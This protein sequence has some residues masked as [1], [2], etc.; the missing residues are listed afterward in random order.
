[1]EKWI[2]VV[3]DP[4]GL[5]GFALFLVFSVLGLKRRTPDASWMTASFIVLAAVGLMGGLGLAY[6]RSPQT[7]RATSSG[8]SAPPM[9]QSK[10][11]ASDTP[12]QL[13]GQVRQETH[14][15]QSPTVSGVQGNVTI[16]Q[17]PV[18][19]PP[20]K[21]RM[22]VTGKWMSGT[23]T[24]PYDSSDKSTL[25]FEFVLQGESLLGNV[26]ESGKD[27]RTSRAIQNGKI[28]DSVVSFYTEGLL[29]GDIPYK[30]MYRGTVKNDE[31]GFV[32]QNTAST[33]G[34]I[35]RFTA[36]RQSE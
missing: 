3:T 6:L 35:E 2:S 30:D 14:G 10:P 1:L 4:L 15:S 7:G 21:Q 25:L 29:D 17:G 13:P 36:K 22:N 8:T 27:Y 24:N 28:E 23:L 9:A 26:T 18:A 5:A 20:G 31:I 16:I 33:G 34:E 19:G 12:S 11:S 32:R